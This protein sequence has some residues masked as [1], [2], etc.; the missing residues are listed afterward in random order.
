[1]KKETK[2]KETKS[3]K[4]EI[5]QAEIEDE[6]EDEIES[7]VE[8]EE[9]D[10]DED[11]EDEE[12]EDPSKPENSKKKKQT[13]DELLTIITNHFS[14]L[15]KLEITF[16]DKEKLFEK[17]QKEFYNSKKKINRELTLVLKRFDK[18]YKSQL[19]K[20]KK[21]RNTENAG[22]GGFNKMKEV[23]E[24][25]RE[26]IGLEKTDIKSRPDVTKLLNQK[27]R[28]GN[29][30]HVKKDENGKETKIIILDKATAKKLK[31]PEGVEIRCR[32]IQTFIAQF[33]KEQV[34]VA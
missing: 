23:P 10:E 6:I 4:V 34:V 8:E 13:G 22:K 20:T 21:P 18:M 11:E 25:L 1:M 17:E 32:D 29:M 19:G 14:D 7:E 2:V 24:C 3:P 16:S 12:E 26:Y 27:F 31:R 5:K 28:D 9:D 15:E 33:Y 30:I